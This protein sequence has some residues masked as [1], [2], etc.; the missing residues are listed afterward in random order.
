MQ[1][2]PNTP[3]FP[4]TL[5]RSDVWRVLCARTVEDGHIVLCSPTAARP[6]WSVHF[7]CAGDDGQIDLYFTERFTSQAEAAASYL[8]RV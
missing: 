4:A 7:A 3:Y 5:R 1:F 8:Q 6:Y 2:I